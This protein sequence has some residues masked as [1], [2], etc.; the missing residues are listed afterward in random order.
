[1]KETGVP[2]PIFL[3]GAERSGTTVLRLM[4]DHH[5]QIAWC[6][7]FEYAVD[8]ISPDGQWPDLQAYYAW[9][10]TH[11][12]FQAAQFAIDTTLDYPELVNSFLLQKR[13]R[14]QK[15]IIGATV[16]RHFDRL[17]H[18][19]PEA[20]FIHIIR[21][22]RDVARSCIGMGWAGNVWCGVERWMEAEA[23]WE[24]LRPSLTPDRYTEVTY[25][26]L[27]A[28]PKETL[29][30][31]SKFIG[32]PYDSAMI[33]YAEKSTYDL[34]DPAF[35]QQWRRKLSEFEIRLVESRIG[36]QLA[37]RGY[38]L[39]ELPSLEV[40]PLMA[41]QLKL[42]NWWSKFQFRLN[43]YGSGLFLSSYLARRIGT[44]QWR[45]R[46]QLKMNAIDVQ[47]LK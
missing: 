34:P 15:P 35:I 9:L 27:I 22:G 39:S 29:T 28:N 26:E 42:Q 21:D 25:E 1:M 14:T 33:S 44:K 11:R 4:L 8:Q 45:D 31:L 32:V 37:T 36:E 13:D 3:V 16:H 24:A 41:K 38:E 43:R 20:R 10:G 19:W 18:V 47:Y 2:D 7:E 17:L 23:L 6:N 46:V 40:T 30:R 5:P 12:I